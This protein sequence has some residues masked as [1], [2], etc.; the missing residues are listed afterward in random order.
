MT[1]QDPPPTTRKDPL[2][3]RLVK[4]VAGRTVARVLR[5]DDVELAIE[6]DDGARLFV[7]VAAGKLDLSVT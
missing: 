1:I 4:L 2:R 7:R 3:E 5:A 6:L